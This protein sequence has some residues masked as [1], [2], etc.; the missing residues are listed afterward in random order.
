[1]EGCTD[2][3]SICSSRR[4]REAGIAGPPGG[5]DGVGPCLMN[6]WAGPCLADFRS[7]CPESHSKEGVMS[8]FQKGDGLRAAEC[9]SSH[10]V[11]G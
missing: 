9:L 4:R 8:S 11:R 6:A 3:G 7:P 10:R 2:A 5:K 1:M